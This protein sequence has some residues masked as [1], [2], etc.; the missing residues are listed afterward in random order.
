LFG[1]SVASAAKWSQRQRVT[2]SVGAKRMGG[3]RKRVLLGEQDWIMARLVEQPELTVRAL[4]V[5]LAERGIRVSH[6]TVWS[7]LRHAGHSFKKN[8]VRHR[9]G[10]ARDRPAAGAVAQVSGPDLT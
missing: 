7:L 9:A 10:A 2:G 3:K 4:A 8:G 5:E 6:N 1:V